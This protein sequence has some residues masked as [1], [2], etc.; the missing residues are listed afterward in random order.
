MAL[1]RLHS[2]MLRPEPRG[3]GPPS[4]PFCHTKP[5][6]LSLSSVLTSF[7]ETPF[8]RGLCASSFLLERLPAWDVQ[9]ARGSNGLC[10]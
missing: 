10:S 4:F 6:S 1:A 2:G 9:T 3:L 8:L 7:P 5:D